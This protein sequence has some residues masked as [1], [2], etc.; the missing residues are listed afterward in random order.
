MVMGAFEIEPGKP[1]V[2]QYRYATYDGQPNSELTNRLWQDF[3]EPP[4]VNRVMK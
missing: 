4:T 1:F 2:S 3:A